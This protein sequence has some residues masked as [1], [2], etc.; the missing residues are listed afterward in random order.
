MYIQSMVTVTTVIVVLQAYL[1]LKTLH[2]KIILT[3]IMLIYVSLLCSE[4][5]VRFVSFVFVFVSCPFMF[6]C[7]YI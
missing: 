2:C 5:S 7:L 6:E 1:S 3:F 4:R